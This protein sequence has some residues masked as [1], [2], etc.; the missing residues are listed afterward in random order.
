VFEEALQKPD[1]K[2]NLLLADDT[3]VN[4]FKG[5]GEIVVTDINLNL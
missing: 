3:P 1:N 4:V 5:E 2:C